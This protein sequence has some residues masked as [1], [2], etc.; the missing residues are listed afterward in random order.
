MNLSATENQPAKD[1]FR[2]KLSLKVA[3][4]V[5]INEVYELTEVTERDL[6]NII[7]TENQTV[8][9]YSCIFIAR[10]SRTTL[11]PCAGHNKHDQNV[12]H[13]GTGTGN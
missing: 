4:W 3:Y 9:F 13:P 2:M 12:N 5:Q 8:C 10:A 6:L 7:N 1:S 11:D